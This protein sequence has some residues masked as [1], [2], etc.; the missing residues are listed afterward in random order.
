M[1]L[2]LKHLFLTCVQLERYLVFTRMQFDHCLFINPHK[3]DIQPTIPQ[4]KGTRAQNIDA[5]NM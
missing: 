1:T 3:C 5:I 4:K 2:L